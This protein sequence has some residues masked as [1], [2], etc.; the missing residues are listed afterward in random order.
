LFLS[1]RRGMLGR[2]GLC[3]ADVAGLHIGLLLGSFGWQGPGKSL[4]S[5]F[6]FS[7]YF[8]FEFLVL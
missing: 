8:C 3:W 4:F 7:F 1:E 6:L 5:P 2:D